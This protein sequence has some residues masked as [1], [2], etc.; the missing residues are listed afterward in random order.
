[1]GIK[2]EKE[3]RLAENYFYFLGPASHWRTVGLGSGE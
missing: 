1:M 2:K 3:R